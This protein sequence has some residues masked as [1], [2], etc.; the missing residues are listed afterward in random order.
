[1]GKFKDAEIDKL[2]EGVDLK[3]LLTLNEVMGLL[4]E[5]TVR[6][7]EAV[8]E[9]QRYLFDWQVHCQENRTDQTG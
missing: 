7:V 5:G 8:S 3:D 9:G 1:M 6:E 4:N 2:F